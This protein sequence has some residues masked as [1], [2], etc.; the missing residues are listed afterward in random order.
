LG[1]EYRIRKRYVNLDWLS[2]TAE[3]FG[4]HKE[5]RRDSVQRL[6]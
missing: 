2:R 4:S 5:W 3:A 1:K 6:T